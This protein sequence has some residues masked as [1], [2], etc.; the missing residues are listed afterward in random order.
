MRTLTYQFNPSNESHKILVGRK[1][2]DASVYKCP[3][4]VELNRDCW[5]VAFTAYYEGLGSS[6]KSD[7]IPIETPLILMTIEE[8][9]RIAG[10]QLFEKGEVT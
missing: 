4:I 9:N 8:A 2:C 1:D 7:G 5:A 6:E 10:M 3:A